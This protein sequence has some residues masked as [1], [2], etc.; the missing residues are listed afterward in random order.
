M[1]GGQVYAGVCRKAA[2]VTQTLQGIAQKGTNVRCTPKRARS[3]DVQ[4]AKRLL[5]TM[6]CKALA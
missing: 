6:Q 5:K 3:K 1:G 2:G 4:C